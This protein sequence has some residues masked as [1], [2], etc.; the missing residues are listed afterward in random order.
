MNGFSDFSAVGYMFAFSAPE[1]PQTPRFESAT[2]TS[3]TLQL[4]ES[5]NDNGVRIKAY[6][7]Y[8]DGGND[9]TSDFSQVTDLSTF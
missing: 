4:F 7:L 6:E 9:L 1:K 8:I 3:V 5:I 2:D